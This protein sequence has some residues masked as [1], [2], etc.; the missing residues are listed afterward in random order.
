MT[1]C[2]TGRRLALDLG[3]ARI[4]VALSDAAGILA[5]PLTALP[6]L[7]MRGDLEALGRLVREHEIGQVIV[8]LP[9]KLSGEEG[10]R[11]RDARCFADRLR[12]HLAP[13]IVALWDE[14][15]TTVE[16]ERVLIA[17][18]VGRRRRRRVIDGMA[19]TLILQSFLDA[20]VRIPPQACDASG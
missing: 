18:D 14:R 5:H 8:G 13:V 10:E 17:A 19:A 1:A 16:A 6:R 11:A 7:G 20:H 9:L 12:A 15:L 4:G 3:D 2:G